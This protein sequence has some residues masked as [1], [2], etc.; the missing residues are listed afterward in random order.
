M[1]GILL[2]SA[3]GEGNERQNCAGGCME[4][5]CN[6]EKVDLCPGSCFKSTLIRNQ[7]TFAIRIECRK[8]FARAI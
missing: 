5:P 6:L 4:V 7:L 2:R 3:G 8:G 1:A